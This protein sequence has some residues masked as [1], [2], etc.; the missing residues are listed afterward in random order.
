MW[1]KLI[2][3]EII[4][5][6][7]NFI[8]KDKVSIIITLGGGVGSGSTKV[9]VKALYE[10]C[11]KIDLVAIKPFS[12]EGNK[13]AMRA[14]STLEFVTCYCHKIDMLQNYTIKQ[15]IDLSMKESFNIFNEKI[16]TYLLEHKKVL[17]DKIQ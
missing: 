3:D 7:K 9:I 12:W 13:K 10:S 8:K 2:D 17:Q 6:I 16:H 5:E 15:D 11:I 1:I 14:N 4:K